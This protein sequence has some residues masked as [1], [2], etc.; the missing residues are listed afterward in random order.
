MTTSLRLGVPWLKS[1]TRIGRRQPNQAAPFGGLG[2][3]G[4]DA[5]IAVNPTGTQIV[6]RMTPEHWLTADYGKVSG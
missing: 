2:A 6:F 5:Y 3:E 4:G 1:G